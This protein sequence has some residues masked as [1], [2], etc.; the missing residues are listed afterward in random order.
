[1]PIPTELCT[2]WRLAA[3]ISVAAPAPVFVWFYA[4]RYDP[5]AWK[6]LLATEA[7]VLAV[8]R[9][10][11]TALPLNRRENDVAILSSLGAAN[12]I[13]L[14]RG[15]LISMLAGFFFWPAEETLS[16]PGMIAWLPGALY[17]T[18]A[19]LD[20]FDGRVARR[21]NRVTPMGEFLDIRFDAIGL[22]TASIVG[23]RLGQLP[24]AYLGAGLA[25]YLFMLGQRL[26]RYRSKP[27]VPLRPRPESR[28]MAGFNMG[29]AG[30]A[31]LPVFRPPVTTVAACVFMTPLLAG[32]L[33]DWLVVS[34]R[35][36]TDAHQRAFWEPRVRRIF[37]EWLPVFARLGLVFCLPA[38]VVTGLLEPVAAT[39]A[40]KPASLEPGGW[41]V[42][43][44]L[45]VPLM[46]ILCGA[47]GRSSALV[48]ILTAGYLLNYRGA[49]PLWYGVLLLGN[50]ILLSGT[51]AFS[52]WK[53]EERFLMIQH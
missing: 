6:W 48:L 27:L 25:F 44:F 32:F 46:M 21:A 3:L 52:L 13:T 53:P 35:L 51:G 43:G 23:Y 24:L 41:L 20:H 17:F 37:T 7:V 31:L 4:G 36:E 16:G 2:R 38:A 15:V 45:G 29:F 19:L 26:R 34:Q 30:V 42:W 12:S 47:A 50:V 39:S 40:L 9:T 14:A 49:N 11:R 28:L 10:F 18:A 1:M 22:L 33:R 5:S 8:L